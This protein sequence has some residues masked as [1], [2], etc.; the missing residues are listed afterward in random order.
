MAHISPLPLNTVLITEDDYH[1]FNDMLEI[2]SEYRVLV[3]KDYFISASI[4]QAYRLDPIDPERWNAKDRA[5]YAL[6][7]RPKN[8]PTAAP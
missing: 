5:I 6:R 1:H 3:H 2:S 7:V 8:V 4:E